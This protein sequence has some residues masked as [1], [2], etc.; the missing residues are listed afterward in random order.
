M[1]RP[2]VGR[3]RSG[4]RIQEIMMGKRGEGRREMGMGTKGRDRWR[5]RRGLRR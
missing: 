1:V 2:G 3:G 5:W 4:A